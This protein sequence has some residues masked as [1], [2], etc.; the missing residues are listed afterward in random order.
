MENK[1]GVQVKLGSLNKKTGIA[2]AVIAIFIIVIW[3]I[4][5]KSISYSEPQEAILAVE[6]NV[7]L[8]PAY[9]I[10][11]HALFFFIKDQNNLG[12]TYVRE[13]L[14]GWKTEFLAWSTI[15]KNRNYEK[16]TGYQGYGEN[17]IYGLIN[18]GDDRVLQLDDKKATILSLGMLPSEVVEEYQL[19]GLSIWYF[20]SD[21]AL[22]E[23]TIKLMNKTTK[24]LI[25]EIDL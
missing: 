6:K 22:K 16:L 12:A 13:G 20:E 18:G 11:N 17:L 8:I 21:T 15:D 14:W 1:R 7:V 4:S 25:D 2:L 5:D 3:L 24:E 9:K 23:G 19:K 10:N